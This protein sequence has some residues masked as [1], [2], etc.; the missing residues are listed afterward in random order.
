VT[1]PVY[2]RV[3][4]VF[5]PSG[6]TETV[7]IIP[8]Q[9]SLYPTDPGYTRIVIPKLSP[10]ATVLTIKIYGPCPSTGFQYEVKCA[11]AL[12]KF[13]ASTVQEDPKSPTYCNVAMN[14]NFFVV[15]SGNATPPYLGLY[16]WVFSDSFGQSKLADGFYKTNFLTAPNDTIEVQN[17]VIV[18]ITD[19][20]P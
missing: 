3:G 11:Q 5:V 19:E 18:A 13:K 20:C 6:T 8:S 10:S 2:N 15:H 14:Q 1:L 4:A 17:G 7:T 9:V 16:D 12:D